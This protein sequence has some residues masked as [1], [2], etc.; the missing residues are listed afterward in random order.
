MPLNSDEA[1]REIK[2]WIQTGRVAPGGLIDEAEAL[3]ELGM[4]RTP[5]R[6]ALLRLQS[7]GY[8]EMRRHKGIRVLPLS[9]SDMREIYQVISALEA[10][11]VALI[12]RREPRAAEFEAI[13][14]AI[15]QMKESQ[16]SKQIEPWGDADEL[17]HRELMRLSGNKKLY[18]TGCQ[19][20]DFAKRAHSVALRMQ[21]DAY[22]AQSTR[23]HAALVK[24][25]MSRDPQ[26]AVTMHQEQRLRGEDALIGIVE[27]FQL[28]SL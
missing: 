7:E 23:A 26:Q 5:V 28:S 21:T 14:S 10:A 4:S 1:Y 12:A 16:A 22:R 18:A 3:K 15:E 27:K 20:R 8:L 24:A 6:E 11:A 2:S 13:Q 19:M 17:F 9:A 25:L